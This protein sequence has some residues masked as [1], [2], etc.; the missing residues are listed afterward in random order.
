MREHSG[1]ER[2]LVARGDTCL[3]LRGQ[4]TLAVSECGTSWRLRVS[5]LTAPMDMG[6]GTKTRPLY[7]LL[8]S[9][10]R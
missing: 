5:R 2:Q 3:P 8:L 9:R 10:Q 7:G 6:A 4:H 1:F